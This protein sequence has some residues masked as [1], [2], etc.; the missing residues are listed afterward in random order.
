MVVERE[1][2]EVFE[3]MHWICF[4]FEFEHMSADGGPADPDEPCEDPTCPWTIRRK[5]EEKLKSLG[6][7]PD[8]V[9][10]EGIGEDPS[11]D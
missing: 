2:Y 4:H 1:R 8:S 5:Y 9:W 11:A 6:V 7:D 10:L 3:R